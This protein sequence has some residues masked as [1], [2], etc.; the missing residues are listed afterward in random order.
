MFLKANI[1]QVEKK[2][3]GWSKLRKKNILKGLH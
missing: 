2:S 1:M 3:L